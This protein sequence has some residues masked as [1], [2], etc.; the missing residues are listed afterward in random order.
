MN[1]IDIKDELPKEAGHYLV[2][3]NYKNK[4]THDVAH[5]WDQEKLDANKWL[6]ADKPYFGVMTAG[7]VT[8]WMPLPEPPIN[9]KER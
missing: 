3:M 8:H 1:W 6:D 2:L 5:W 4:H 7:D 9:N